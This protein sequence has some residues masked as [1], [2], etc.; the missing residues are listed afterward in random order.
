MGDA[1]GEEFCL[2]GCDRQGESNLVCWNAIGGLNQNFAH[3]QIGEGE[4]LAGT[5]AADIP[6][7]RDKVGHGFDG[8]ER[9]RGGMRNG[10]D[11]IARTEQI[12]GIAIEVRVLVDENA[13]RERIVVLKR[14]GFA[15]AFADEI[16]QGAKVASRQGRNFSGFGLPVAIWFGHGSSVARPG[17]KV[18]GKGRGTL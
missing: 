11:R 10:L 6:V 9:D 1:A 14:R 7:I 15:E 2:F 16:A 18:I 3:A 17:Q 5:G 4:I 12:D 8:L 13:D